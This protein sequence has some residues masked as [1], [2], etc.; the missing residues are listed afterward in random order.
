MAVHVHYNS[1]NSID[2]FYHTTTRNDQ[3][4]RRLENVNHEFY[5]NLKFC[6]RVSFVRA[7][8]AINKVNDFRVPH[9]SWAKYRIKV[10]LGVEACI[11]GSQRTSS[12]LDIHCNVN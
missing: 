12:S 8:T 5:S 7:L 9:D 3:I 4:L 11:I 2:V 1:W 6:A 10:A